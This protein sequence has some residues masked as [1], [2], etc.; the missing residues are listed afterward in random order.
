MLKVRNTPPTQCIRLVGHLNCRNL[1]ELDLAVAKGALAKP[2]S[3]GI[4]SSMWRVSE[5]FVTNRA[6]STTSAP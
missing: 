4:R 5:D 1:A 2:R 3:P 6:M